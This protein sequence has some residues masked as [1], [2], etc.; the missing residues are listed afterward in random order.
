MTTQIQSFY[1]GGVTA[2]IPTCILQPSP[3]EQLQRLM[4]ASGSGREPGGEQ[5]R[6]LRLWTAQPITQSHSRHA[7]TLQFEADGRAARRGLRGGVYGQA[8]LENSGEPARGATALSLAWSKCI[9]IYLYMYA[10][11]FNVCQYTYKITTAEYGY[12]VVFI[13]SFGR[14]SLLFQVL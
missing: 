13:R 1:S 7:T 2:E 11:V 6:V 10:Y 3:H 14:V 4:I 9:C 5:E 12:R 8:G